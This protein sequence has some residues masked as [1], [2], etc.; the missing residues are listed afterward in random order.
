MLQSI[1][2]SPQTLAA[3]EHLSYLKDGTSVMS[4]LNTRDHKRV[5][6]MF[7]VMVAIFLLLGGVFALAIRGQAAPARPV[8]LRRDDLQP[9]LHPARHGDD[10]PV[11]DPGDPVRVRQLRRCPS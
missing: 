5:G 3:P 9:A 4:W 7:L 11:H 2:G 1:D 6:I 8:P 10:L